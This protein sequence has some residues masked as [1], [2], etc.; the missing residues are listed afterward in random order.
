MDLYAGILDDW[1]NLY[2]VDEW[3]DM[4]RLV[5]SLAERKP[6]HWRL[7]TL[8]CQACGGSAQQS[9]PAATAIACLHTAIILIDDLLD[10]DPK[11]EYRRIGTGA[12]ANLASAF[13]S[14][15]L[16]AIVQS[17]TS[18]AVKLEA[19]HALNAMLASTALGQDWDSRPVE[20]EAAYWRIV[21][22]KSAPFFHAA[23]QVGALFG[24][25]DLR[26]AEQ[27]GQ[28]G[29][30]YGEMIQIHD[31]LGDALAVPANPDWKQ[32]RSP[33]PILFAERVVHP[34]QPRFRQL[35][36]E[37]L[38]PG[39]LEEAQAILLRCGAVS[40]CIDQLLNRHRQAH[41]MLKELALQQEPIIAN[42]LDELIQP[43]VELYQSLGLDYPGTTPVLIC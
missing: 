12:A 24:A 8:A 3:P 31:D 29:G 16:A 35:R 23:I 20:S 19:L 11:G 37:I 7:P 5:T 10:D 40:Y 33:L 13:Q 17:R 28:I 6:K 34:E 2:K 39:R 21:R 38:E 42:L 9:L 26:T 22:Y 14:A 1:K 25:A 41:D 27:I 30:L 15:G 32:Q 43:V 4:T 36:Q 18:E